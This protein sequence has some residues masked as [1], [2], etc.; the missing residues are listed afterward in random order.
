VAPHAARLLDAPWC[1]LDYR[2]AEATGR[3][4]SDIIN[5]D[6]E[7]AFRTLER[8]AMAQAIDEP[9]QVIATG[10]GWAAE[11][12]NLA[13]V[14]GRALVIYLSIDPGVAALRLAGNRDRPLLAGDSIAS[15]LHATLRQRE[16]SYRL[17]DLE[18]PSGDAPPEAVAA[19]IA[20][21]AR[22]YGG[23]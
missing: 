7:A 14:A 21:A 19:G 9:P 22:Q 17:A 8:A 18:V 10:G 1:D 15:K 6:G 12:G 16:A 2:I 13:A 4:I 3:S 5:M 23:W 11:P 20:T